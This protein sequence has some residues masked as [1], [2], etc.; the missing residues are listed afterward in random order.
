MLLFHTTR[1]FDNDS[2]KIIQAKSL[3]EIQR[4]AEKTPLGGFTPN[5]QNRKLFPRSNT[6]TRNAQI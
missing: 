6:T 5:W 1:Y 4:I 3:E 2:K